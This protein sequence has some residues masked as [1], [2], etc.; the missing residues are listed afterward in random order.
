MFTSILAATDGT[1]LAE[2]AVAHASDLAKAFGARLMLVTVT[3]QAPV[4]DVSELSGRHTS[5][6][7][8]QIRQANAEQS[9]R[10]LEKAAS[11][12]GV[13]VETLHVEDMQPFQGILDA[14]KQSGAD[15]IVMGS[16]GRRGFERLILGSQASKVLSLAEVPVLIIK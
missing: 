13:A 14:A 2:K 10:I 11:T 7:F 16:H 5:T 12:V 8:D 4:F 9:Q 1:L 15:L 6:V 3:E